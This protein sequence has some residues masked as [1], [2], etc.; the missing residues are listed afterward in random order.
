MHLGKVIISVLSYY[1][2]TICPINNQDDY[3]FSS[4]Y[5]YT[6]RAQAQVYHVE[7]TVLKFD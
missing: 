7:S 3:N 1:D 6:V 2:Y 4:S 5:S